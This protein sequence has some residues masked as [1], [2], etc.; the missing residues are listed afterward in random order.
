MLPPGLRT[1]IPRL[2][3]RPGDTLTFQ[4]GFLPLAANITLV[5]PDDEP[6]L[7]VPLPNNQTISWQ[8]PTDLHTSNDVLAVLFFRAATGDASYLLWLHP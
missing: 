8:V 6:L 2:Q 3:V 7:Y 4:L 5:G 1:D